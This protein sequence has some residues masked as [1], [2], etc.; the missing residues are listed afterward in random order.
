[1]L[2]NIEKAKKIIDY[3]PEYSVKDG[4]KEATKWYWN[5]LK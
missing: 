5:N 1:S 2:A 4:L 3:N